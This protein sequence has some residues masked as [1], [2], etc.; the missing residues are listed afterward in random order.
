[1]KLS[2]IA[3]AGLRKL[4]LNHGTIGQPGYL[5]GPGHSLSLVNVVIGPNGGGKSTVVDTV[6]CLLDPDL[7]STIVR[8]NLRIGTESGFRLGFDDGSYLM[9]N[10]NK[11]GIDKAGVSAIAKIGGNYLTWKGPISVEP[12]VSIPPDLR[13]LVFGIGACI[14]YR[15][16][17]DERGVATADWLAPLNTHAEYLNG[18]N[19]FPLDPDQPF[20]DGLLNLRINH[21]PPF[22]ERD[23]FTIHT[24]FND[25]LSQSNHVRISAIPS[26]WRA[27]GGLLGWLRTRVEGSLCIVEEPETHMH[28]TLQ[29]IA[30]REVSKIASERDLQVFITSHSAITIDV[31]SSDPSM[32]LFEA[33]GWRFQSLTEPAKALLSL[34]HRPSDLCLANGIVWVEGPSDRIYLLHWL[35]LW[36]VRENCLLPQENVDYAFCSYGGA[37]LSHYTGG[38]AGDAIDIFKINPN[39]FV[40]MDRDLDFENDNDKGAVPRSGRSPKAKMLASISKSENPLRRAWV[41]DGYTIESYLP[42]EF[43]KTYYSMDGRRLRPLTKKSKVDVALKFADSFANF[44]KAHSTPTLVHMIQE[45]YQCITQWRR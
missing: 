2:T 11:L 41:T 14:F 9:F 39:A 43:R 32:R 4:E 6:R 23:Q 22:I 10:F 24:N 33:N 45:I 28:P 31:A 13:D 1:M 29:R 38:G 27:L 7:L 12:G 35:K 36:C 16:N 37:A 30:I 20:Y 15:N 26:G 25:D 18:T 40:L 42:D 8:E 19:R 5:S 34:G 3:F 21:I 17:H 44:D